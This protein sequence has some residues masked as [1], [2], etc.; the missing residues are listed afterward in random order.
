MKIT[1]RILFAFLFLAFTAPLSFSQHPNLYLKDVYDLEWCQDLKI[2]SLTSGGST[3]TINNG[4]AIGGKS[5]DV[6]V[7]DNGRRIKQTQARGQFLIVSSLSSDLKRLESLE[8]G[9]TSTYFIYDRNHH[10]THKIN[11]LNIQGKKISKRFPAAYSL[12]EMKRNWKGQLIKKTVYD[13]DQSIVEYMDNIDAVYSLF[14]KVRE[15][16]DYRYDE[17]DQLQYITIRRFSSEDQ[18]IKSTYLVKVNHENNLP[19]Y[20]D[21]TYEDAE[22]G[23]SQEKRYF[24]YSF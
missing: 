18:K 8:M 13:Y 20:L 11:D 19:T 15:T 10:L 6:I 2:K 3:Y 9:P 21:I 16:W 5:K 1:T 12:E 23:T 14:N 17:E 7:E 22:R 24:E 4:V